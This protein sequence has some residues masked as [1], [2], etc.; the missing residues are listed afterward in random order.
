MQ[1]SQSSPTRT[2]EHTGSNHVLVHS[3]SRGSNVV[4]Q[5]APT[6]L[7]LKLNGIIADSENSTLPV[8]L[9]PTTELRIPSDMPTYIWPQT[10]DFCGLKTSAHAVKQRDKQSTFDVTQLWDTQYPHNFGTELAN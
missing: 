6:V 3:F 5:R 2:V 1:C 9:Q 7:Q 4:Y 8:L 10:A